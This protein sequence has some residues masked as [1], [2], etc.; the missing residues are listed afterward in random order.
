MFFRLG[1]LGYM[2]TP[3]LVEARR[4]IAEEL[5][6]PFAQE[7]GTRVVQRRLL[8]FVKA[9]ILRRITQPVFPDELTGSKPFIYALDRPGAHI[10]SADQRLEMAEIDWRPKEDGRR[11]SYL[12]LDHSLAIGD[13][14]LALMR[15]CLRHQVTLAQWTG[16]HSLKRHP[17][18]IDVTLENGRRETVTLVP[19]AVCKLVL[20]SRRATWLFLE[21]DLGSMTIAPSHWQLR[22]WRRKFLAYR[23]LSESGV[24]KSHYGAGSM[25]VTVVTTS[26]TRAAHLAESCERAGGDERFWFTSMD[27]LKND[28][29]GEIW[30]VAGKGETLYSLLPPR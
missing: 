26:P 6:L 11:A 7:S 23:A 27:E 8:Q 5:D 17:A 18:Q 15:A 30:R 3:Q 14:F 12:F 4:Q 21:M 1:T 10:V 22:A 9:G 13:F 2:S 28:L 24:L 20:P 25:I 19:D 16:D 29:F